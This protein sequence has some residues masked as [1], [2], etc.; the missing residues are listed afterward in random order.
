MS[1]SGKRSLFALLAALFLIPVITAEF[2]KSQA[3]SQLWECGHRIS[4]YYRIVGNKRPRGRAILKPEEEAKISHL[5]CP[6]SGKPYRKK[7]S[8]DWRDFEV[9]CEGSSHLPLSLQPD[10]PRY[11][12]SYPDGPQLTS[13]PNS[14][15]NSRNFEL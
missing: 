13:N 1:Q 7:V 12:V 14:A 15:I 4:T 3:E 8:Q 5:N 6:V 11:G 2:R 9:F 10:Y